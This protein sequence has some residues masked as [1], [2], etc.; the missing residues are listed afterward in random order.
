MPENLVTVDKRELQAIRGQSEEL[1]LFALL[2]ISASLLLIYY[3]Q[4]KLNSR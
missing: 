4:S 3:N 2:F 1:L